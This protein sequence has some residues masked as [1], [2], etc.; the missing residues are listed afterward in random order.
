VVEKT[1]TLRWHRVDKPEQNLLGL[2]SEHS[3]SPTKWDGFAA[4]ARRKP[5]TDHKSSKRDLYHCIYIQNTQR[6]RSSVEGN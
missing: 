3:L 6:T 5:I 4:I 1:Q 2:G